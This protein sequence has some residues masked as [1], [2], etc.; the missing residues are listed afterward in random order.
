MK[1][2][3][4]ALFIQKD[5][6]MANFTTYKTGGKAQYFCLPKNIEEIKQAINFAKE[7]KLDFYILG[8]GSNILVGDLGIKGLVC[9]LKDFEKIEI[10]NNTITALAGTPLDKVIATS[11]LNNLGGLEKLSGIP[12]S[13][14]GAVFMNAGAFNGETWQNITSVE[15]LKDGQVKTIKKEEVKAEYRKVKGLENCLIL[16]A[17]WALT[18]PADKNLREEILQKRKLKQPLEYPSAGSVFKRPVGDYASRLIDSCNLRG[19]TIGGAQ[20]AKKHA[21]FI[22][23]YNK[24]TAQDIRNLMKEVQKIVKE[25]TGFSLE[26]E[27]ILWGDFKN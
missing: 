1:A 25:K 6:S 10:K 9:C 19:L 27:Q 17:T 2:K 11:V 21:G 13:V 14:G 8:L 24:A 5:I 18:E 23:N 26:L 15:V 4:Q 22:I 16:S 7:N 12:G 20:V 3:E